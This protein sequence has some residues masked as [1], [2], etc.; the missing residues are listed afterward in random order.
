[1]FKD[2]HTIFVQGGKGGDGCLAFR[3][4]KYV[5]RGGPSGGNGGHGGSVILIASSQLS[6]FSDMAD[7]VYFRAG[8]GQA[9]Q[10]SLKTGASADDTEILVP[11]GTIVRERE[12]GRR[13]RDI[14]QDGMRVE[15]ALGGSP[16]RGNASFKSST[17]QVPRETTKGSE[18]QS[19]WLSLELKLLAD[20][21]LVGLPN[22]GKSTLL[23]RLSRARPKVADYPFTTLTPFLGIVATDGFRSF[24]MADLPGL[25]EGASEGLGL[26]H[27]F[28][29][30]VERTRV[31]V[32][33]VDLHGDAAAA[34]AQIRAELVAYGHGLAER[35]EIVVANKIDQG[36]NEAGLKELQALVDTKVVPISGVTG[37]GLPQ[38][39]KEIAKQ[40]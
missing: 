21:G 23:S 6:T 25:I 26:G 30:H 3:R 32:H 2:E 22:A 27:Q 17:N 19:F 11:V 16:G 38:L 9:G 14:D 8:K 34:Y 40:L 39:I 4:E 18:G 12:S 7:Q 37:E 36:P 5:P 15:V 35:P 10:G 1:M 28:L 29:R 33:V 31:L 24:T 13:V 20:V